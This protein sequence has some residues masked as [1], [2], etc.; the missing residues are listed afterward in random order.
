MSTMILLNLFSLITKILLIKVLYSIPFNPPHHL[1]IS[2]ETP[3][4]KGLSGD[5]VLSED[6]TQHLT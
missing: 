1:K 6:L 2:L 5:E 4:W 3:S